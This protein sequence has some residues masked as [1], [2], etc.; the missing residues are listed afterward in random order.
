[1]Q[2]LLHTTRLYYWFFIEYWIK[3]GLDFYPGPFLFLTIQLKASFPRQEIESCPLNEKPGRFLI[4]PGNP[5][6][7]VSGNVIL[8]PVTGHSS[9][10]L[11]CSTPFDISL[12]N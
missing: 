6:K 2:P 5:G 10:A 8:V 7:R 11:D 1:L 3:T 4:L 9:S 12:C